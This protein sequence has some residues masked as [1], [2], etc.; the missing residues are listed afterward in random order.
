MRALL[1]LSLLAGFSSIPASAADDLETAQRS[2]AAKKFYAG[3]ELF[4]SG[5]Y[6]AAAE[7]WEE[8]YELSKEPDLLW[9]LVNAYE[10]AGNYE[11]ALERLQSY[12]EFATEDEF[13]KVRERVINL[14]ERVA[15]LRAERE[16][17]E[18]ERDAREAELERERERVAQLEREQQKRSSTLGG[19]ILPAVSAG[20]GGIAV[21]TGGIFHSR[22]AESKAELD[23]LCTMT[24]SGRMC[25]TTADDIRAQRSTRAALAW[26]GYGIGT[27]AIATGAVL[28]ALPQPTDAPQAWVAPTPG[29]VLA[30]VRY[31]F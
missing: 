14:S 2:R 30:G 1:I 9:N 13:D 16:K 11:L 22:A 4:D 10:R 17:R 31:A 19:L 23:A 5:R 3:K 6:E 24:E 21:A 12:R 26:T 15:S 20:V 27:A 28:L 25:P 8:A 18:K 29:G 7:L